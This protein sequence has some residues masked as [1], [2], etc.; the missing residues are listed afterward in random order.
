MLA[1]KILPDYKTKKRQIRIVIGFGE[2]AAKT[3]SL[4]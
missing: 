4:F 2:W 1:S 3:F